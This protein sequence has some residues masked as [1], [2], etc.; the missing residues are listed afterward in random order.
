MVIPFEPFAEAL[1]DYVASCP[2]AELT[3]QVAHRR[4]E[5][6]LLVPEL[7]DGAVSE[8]DGSATDPEQ[9]RFR[10]FEAVASLITTAA[11]ARPVI[12]RTRRS[13]LGR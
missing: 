7:G 11:R 2:P 13:A 10:L 12:S 9:G 1:R 3:V 6:A 8:A 5:V 4:R